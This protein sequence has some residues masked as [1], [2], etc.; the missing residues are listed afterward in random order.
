MTKLA[1][2]KAA[3]L[4]RI[5][6]PAAVAVAALALVAA[7]AGCG[8][9]SGGGTG[10]SASPVTIRFVWWGNDDRAKATNSAVQLFEQ[11]NPTI[12]VQTEYSAYD[13]YYQKLSTQIAGGAA[14]DLLQ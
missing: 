8:S 10:T 11:R 12:K 14:P 1:P 9:S 4:A 3:P 6:K 2:P 13:A 5:G 7:V